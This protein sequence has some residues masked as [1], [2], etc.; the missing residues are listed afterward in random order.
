MCTPSSALGVASTAVQYV[1]EK[2]A[3]AA[4]NNF[5]DQKE[6]GVAKEATDAY[7]L[8]LKDREQ[9]LMEE[10]TSASEQGI[11]GIVANAQEAGTQKAAF[12]SQGVSGNSVDEIM[13]QYSA[14]EERTRANAETDLRWKQIAAGR[15]GDALRATATSRIAESIRPRQ[16]GPSLLAATLQAGGQVAGGYADYKKEK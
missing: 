4:A 7:S 5:Q 13:S 15:T 6:A 1:G 11:A 3:A 16:A 14:I 9:V 10:S 8:G 2:K 12:G